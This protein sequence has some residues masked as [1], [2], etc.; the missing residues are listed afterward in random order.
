MRAVLVSY[1][2]SFQLAGFTKLGAGT[3]ACDRE[4]NIYNEDAMTGP[5]C[6]TIGGRGDVIGRRCR[7]AAQTA[8]RSAASYFGPTGLP[9][10]AG[11][12]QAGQP[13]L[14]HSPLFTHT[15]SGDTTRPGHVAN[16]YNPPV[17]K[18]TSIVVF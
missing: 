8:R 18:N 12:A 14:A 5:M 9:G 6:R 3:V 1:D 4:Y 16:D 7:M 17:W 15:G 13:G 11:G 10:Q 2:A